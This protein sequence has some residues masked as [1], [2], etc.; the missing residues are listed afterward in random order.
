[1]LSDFSAD[2]LELLDVLQVDKA[3]VLGIS[4]GGIIA[5]TLAIEHPSRVDRL[6][7]VS[8]ANHFWPYLTDMTRLLAKLLGGISLSAYQRTVELLGTAP[9][10][11]D[12]HQDRVE[13]KISAARQSRISRSSVLR[14][15]R[16][17][18]VSEVRP[19]DYRIEAPTLVLAG[20]YDVLVPHCYARRMAQEIPGSVFEIVAGCGH[21]PLDEAPERVLPRVIEFLVNQGEQSSALESSGS[22]QGASADAADS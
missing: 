13:Q 15:L 16:C 6:V 3:H 22:R 7:L 4:L 11:F 9:E 5:Q 14:Q 12:A 2:L 21:N 8:C 17:L 20:E 10:Y 18:A 19:E 1:M